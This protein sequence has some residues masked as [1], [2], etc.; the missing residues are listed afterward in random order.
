[1]S[2]VN[3]EEDIKQSDKKTHN[4]NYKKGYINEILKICLTAGGVSYNG[5]KVL[6]GDRETYTN[7]IRR[8]RNN[9]IV[10][11]KRIGSEF[12]ATLSDF[13]TTN[14]QYIEYFI[15]Y[16]GTYTRFIVKKLRVV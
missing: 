5:L 10:T 4:L 1:M 7:S 13:G 2:V 15:P 8:L 6:D 14:E 3:D 9:G 12:V 11:I 16:L